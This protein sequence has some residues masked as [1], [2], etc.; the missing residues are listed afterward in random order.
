MF[1]MPVFLKKIIHSRDFFAPTSEDP[2]DHTVANDNSYSYC[3]V[4]SENG[5]QRKESL[6]FC[7]SQKIT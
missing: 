7:C 2:Q 5:M 4:F 3:T 1:V 6:Y